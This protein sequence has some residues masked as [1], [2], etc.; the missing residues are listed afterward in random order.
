[1]SPKSPARR[2]FL[3]GG[4]S[5]TSAAFLSLNWADI[6]AAAQQADHMAHMAEST[7]AP[8]GFTT[9]TPAEATEVEAIASQIIPS[10]ESPGAR[11]AGVVYFIDRALGTFLASELPALRRGLED[12]QRNFAAHS[13]TGKPFS[14]VGPAYQRAWLHEVEATPFFNSVRRLTLVGLI[15]LPK[16]GGNRN[17]LGWKLIG[18][19]DRHFWQP[20]FGHYDADYAGFEPYPGTQPFTA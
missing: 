12:F 8:V 18:F 2:Q 13:S 16:Y 19:E 9:L 1:M 3:S 7:A 11:E 5:I 4:A 15:A 20:P 10:G 17:K 14:A 6:A